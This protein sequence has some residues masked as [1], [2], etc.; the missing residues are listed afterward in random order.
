VVE[1]AA[2]GAAAQ[3][4]PKRG[5]LLSGRLRGVCKI[6]ADRVE[7][8]PAGGDNSLKLIFF[9]LLSALFEHFGAECRL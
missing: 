8:A 3:T 2:L 4:A 5:C 1:K 9:R 6:Q 7:T